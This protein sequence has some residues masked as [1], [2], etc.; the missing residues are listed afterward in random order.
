MLL[1]ILAVPRFVLDHTHASVVQA[2]IARTCHD[3]LAHGVPP[4]L[5]NRDVEGR[6]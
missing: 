4:L 5:T 3:G 2:C 6:G 1:A